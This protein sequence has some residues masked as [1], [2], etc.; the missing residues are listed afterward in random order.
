L[1]GIFD[2]QFCENE[3]KLIWGGYFK[4]DAVSDDQQIVGNISTSAG[5]TAR[6][7]PAIGK[8][9]KIKSDILYLLN[10]ENANRRLL[11][12]TEQSMLDYFAKEQN[13]GRLPSNIEL[14]L[15]ELPL[16]LRKQ[17][18]EARKIASKEVSPA[19]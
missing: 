10:V 11:I 18:E 15:V 7:K 8:Y 12:F 3:L 13:V 16:D 14:I 4:F 6:G 9:H 5:R 17:L 19:K 1:P 2:C